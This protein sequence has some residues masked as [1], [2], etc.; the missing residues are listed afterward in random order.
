[1]SPTLTGLNQI[2]RILCNGAVIAYYY[3]KAGNTPTKTHEQGK[4]GSTEAVND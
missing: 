2:N 4:G 1:M 3:D